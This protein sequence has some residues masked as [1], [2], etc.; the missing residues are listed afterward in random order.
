MTSGAPGHESSSLRLKRGLEAAARPTTQ[1]ASGF[2]SGRPGTLCAFARPQDSFRIMIHRTNL[3]I[4]LPIN[5][6]DQGVNGHSA[7]PQG[8]RL[9][10]HTVPSCSSKLLIW[11][12]ITCPIATSVPCDIRRLVQL[13]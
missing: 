4:P 10:Y 11:L 13:V 2:F 12:P 1:G 5:Q 6:I 8:R 9:Q 3:G 7:T